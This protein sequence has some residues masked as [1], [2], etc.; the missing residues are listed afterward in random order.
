M[1]AR[2]FTGGVES[3][4][5]RVRERGDSTV[6]FVADGGIVEG[7]FAEA[8]GDLMAATGTRSNMTTRRGNLTDRVTL[9]GY[10]LG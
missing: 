7:A 5:I 8:G 6:V 9:L 2:F 4:G 10:L 3:G 1:Y